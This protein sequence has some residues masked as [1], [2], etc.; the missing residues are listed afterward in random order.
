MLCVDCVCRALNVLAKRSVLRS[1]LYVLTACQVVLAAR[2]CFRV[3]IRAL[4]KITALVIVAT[5]GTVHAIAMGWQQW[6]HGHH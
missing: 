4:C 1:V 2:A 6:L 3:C 5:V